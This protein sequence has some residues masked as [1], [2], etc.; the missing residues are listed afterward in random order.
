MTTLVTGSAGFIGF[1]LAS[2]LLREGERVVGIDDFNDYYSPV[3]KRAR[4]AELMRVA[5][6]LGGDRFALIEGSLA[7]VAAVERCFAIATEPV[8]RVCNL[9]AQAGVRYSQSN[10]AAYVQANIVGFGN[11]LEA[12]R[13]H[14]V[15]RLVYA[16]SSSVYGPNAPRPFNTEY[17]AD[18]PISL[19]AATKRANELMAHAYTHNFGLRT[20]GLRYFTVYGPWGRPDMAVWKFTELIDRGRELTLYNN[21]QMQRDFSYIDDVVAGTLGALRSG[22]VGMYDL[23][24]LGSDGPSQ[25]GDL[26][27]A[28][29]AALGKTAN[30]RLTPDTPAGDVN[31]T[32]ACIDRSR[33]L[34]GFSPST[35]LDAGVRKFVE[36]YRAHPEV[37][38][39]VAQFRETHHD[40]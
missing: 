7:D 5:N 27:A 18:T 25:L 31:A 39:A 4:H 15:D 32:H 10:P 17:R 40:R 38:Q 35:P 24:N 16:S 34:L 29:G 20:V 19:Y 33:E 36:W 9:A 23:F 37:A 30:T 3:L 13:Q 12:C 1:H 21:G 2:T 28:I 11:L 8:E 26:V 6:E 14:A 22:R